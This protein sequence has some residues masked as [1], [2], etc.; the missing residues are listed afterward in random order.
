M[1]HFIL[2]VRKKEAFSVTTV[3]PVCSVHICM[4]LEL[5]KSRLPT[6]LHAIRWTMIGQRVDFQVER[7]PIRVFCI[8]MFDFSFN[9][10]LLL[11][12]LQ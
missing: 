1:V 2:K 3:S 7:M 5:K 11:A 9:V 6:T 12:C 8:H 4:H 10:Y